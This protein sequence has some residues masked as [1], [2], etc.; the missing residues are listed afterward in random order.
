MSSRALRRH[1]IARVKAR[2][3][4]YFTAKHWVG[5]E[6]A[7]A[8]ADWVNHTYQ[9]RQSCSCPMCGNPRHHAKGKGRLT[10]QER[11]A[12]LD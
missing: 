9:H 8:K 3:L 6:T 11:R 12:D 10:L 4:A 1:H 2:V 5:F 7:A